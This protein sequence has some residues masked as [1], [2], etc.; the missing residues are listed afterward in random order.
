MDSSSGL[1]IGQ[2]SDS[3]SVLSFAYNLGKCPGLGWDLRGIECIL[4]ASSSDCTWTTFIARCSLH[5]M[6]GDAHEMSPSYQLT[7]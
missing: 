7:V 2:L 6:D 5:Q 4:S 3:F 1:R